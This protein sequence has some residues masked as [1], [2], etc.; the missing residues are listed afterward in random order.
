[1]GKYDKEQMLDRI[2][3]R[4]AELG[5]SPNAASAAAGERSYLSQLRRLKD[6]A[7]RLDYI[8]RVCEFL[9]LRLHWALTGKGSRLLSDPDLSEDMTI[10]PKISW[11]AASGFDEAQ[12]EA[13]DYEA[14]LLLPGLAG[15]PYFALDVRGDSMDR[16]APEGATIVVNSRERQLEARGFY[17]FSRSDGSEATF[18]R[19][20]TKPNR[21]EP[22]S[23]NPAHE[24][25][26][27]EAPPKVVGRVRRVI[28]DL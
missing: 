22:F 26:Y 10:V 4:C 13:L 12:S 6:R 5:V 11:V 18:K 8:A 15:G 23:S 3:R 9:G 27:V 16:V 19:W 17:I 25:I 20:M 1:M 28:L 7:P 2:E 24:P 14:K 21:L